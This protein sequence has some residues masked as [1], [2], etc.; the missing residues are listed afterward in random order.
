MAVQAPTAIA[1]TSP[2]HTGYKAGAIADAVRQHDVVELSWLFNAGADIDELD[3]HGETPLFRAA[4]S[5]DAVM[6]FLLLEGRADPRHRSPAGLTALDLARNQQCASLIGAMM[7]S[8]AQAASQ[9]ALGRALRGLPSEL[10]RRC[11]DLAQ[12]AAAEREAEHEKEGEEEPAP[13][14]LADH[15]CE[16]R[17]MLEDPSDFSDCR[18]FRPAISGVAWTAPL[19]RQACHLGSAAYYCDGGEEVEDYIAMEDYIPMDMDDVMEDLLFRDIT[20]EDYEFLLQLDEGIAR[21]TAGKAEVS[22]LEAADPEDAAGETCAVCLL[23]FEDDEPQGSVAV[24]QCRHLFHQECISKWLLERSRLCP[25][26]G[27]AACPSE[28]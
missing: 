3:A 1:P 12:V 15:D 10:R 2:A 26:C 22:C 27:E 11:R 9:E 23:P 8:M 14:A 21:D 24:L 17:G 19:S 16:G 18:T 13:Q 4:A 28:R 20:P 25:L 5:G 7:P 6:T